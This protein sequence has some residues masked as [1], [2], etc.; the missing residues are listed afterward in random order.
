MKYEHIYYI[1]QSLARVKCRHS[2]QIKNTHHCCV[3][4]VHFK[5]TLKTKF[6]KTENEINNKISAYPALRQKKLSTSTLGQPVQNSVIRGSSHQFMNSQKSS[7]QMS[8]ERHSQFSSYH[9]HSHRSCDHPCATQ[10]RHLMEMLGPCR[11]VP[12]GCTSL[13]SLEML[14]WPFYRGL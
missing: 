12:H 7:I 10:P 3:K 4:S 8:D 5:T 13:G 11:P 6:Y 2:K 9:P 1:T 14:T